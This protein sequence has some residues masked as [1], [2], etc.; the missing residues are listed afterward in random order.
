MVTDE[1]VTGDPFTVNVVFRPDIA[2]VGNVAPISKSVVSKVCIAVRDTVPRQQ[3]SH[4]W[5]G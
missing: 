3:C 2:R 1:P 5:S 4:Q